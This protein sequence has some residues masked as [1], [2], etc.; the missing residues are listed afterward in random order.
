MK[1]L[2]IVGLSLLGILVLYALGMF[3]WEMYG[4]ATQLPQAE[5]E[6]GIDLGTPY[7]NGR[8]VIQFVQ[9]DEGGSAYNA[10][11]RKDDVLNQ[12]SLAEF[13]NAYLDAD[14]SFTFAV[15][16]GNQNLTVTIEK[17]VQ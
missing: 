17:N 7:V 8:E 12:L 1:K 9:V 14:Q 5:K 16:R 13:A 10:G 6:M 2:I 15:S 3:G 4:Q 11:I